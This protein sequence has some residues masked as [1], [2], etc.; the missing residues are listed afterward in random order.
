MNESKHY[1][2]VWV[3]LFS[4]G[5]ALARLAGERYL[6]HREWKLSWKD[7]GT[8]VL[9]AAAGYIVFRMRHGNKRAG[10]FTR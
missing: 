10:V 5:T 7:A 3:M 2:P 1:A 9:G 8:A 6:L 4:T